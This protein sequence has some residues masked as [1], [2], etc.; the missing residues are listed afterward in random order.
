[1]CAQSA[2]FVIR[3]TF[4]G[5]PRAGFGVPSTLTAPGCVVGVGGLAALELL[6]H[7]AAAMM[8]IALR[9]AQRTRP[10]D[11]EPV[12]LRI[13]PYAIRER[14]PLSGVNLMFVHPGRNGHEVRQ[15]IV[16]RRSRRSSSTVGPSKEWRLHPD[17]ARFRRPF[18]VLT[19]APRSASEPLPIL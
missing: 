11:L 1:H 14:P 18:R 4:T 2:P 17:R 15:A 13:P 9:P 6:L 19:W 7:A 5:V 12:M 16:S 8:S 3:P 10:F